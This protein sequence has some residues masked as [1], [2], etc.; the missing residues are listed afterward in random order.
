[1]DFRRSGIASLSLAVVF[2]SGAIS[3]LG[4]G[5][6]QRYRA[7]LDFSDQSEGYEWSSGPQDVWRLKE[8]G[9]AL[10]DAF[11]V[12]L[13]PSQVVFGCH[14]SNVV[15]AT[16]FP[17]QAGEIVAASQGKGEH[18]TS[19]WL[20]FHPARLGEL[21]PERTVAGQ[22]DASMVPLAK[23]LAAHKMRACWQS[24]DHPMIPWKK[25]ITFDLE[26]REGPRRFYSLDTDTG[27]VEYVD[28]FRTRPLPV[29][30]PASKSFDSKTAMEVFDGVWNAF[31]REYAM[32]VIKPQVDWAKLRQTY[33]P[34]AAAAKA[35]RELATVISEMLDHLEDLH[36]YV[37]VDGE[38]VP[39]YNRN[40]PLNANPKAFPRL[41]GKLAQT[42]HDLDWGARATASAT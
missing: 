12:K 14:E 15:W 1:M 36:V 18:V 6:G 19:I 22:G 16:V 21:F 33:R 4:D 20:R 3:A 42:G 35:N 24:G 41:I 40:R 9:Y 27:N 32:F 17:D 30:K 13:G 8:F 34:R 39:G 38:Y 29:P 26:T 10:G 28:F 5:L 31:D 7:T 2:C 25:S 11:R 23:R 37:Q